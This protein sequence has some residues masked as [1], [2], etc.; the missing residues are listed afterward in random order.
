L[1]YTVNDGVTLGTQIQVGKRR[2]SA[3]N[4]PERRF[5][6]IKWTSTYDHL[7][8][9]SGCKNVSRE[10]KQKKSDAVGGFLVA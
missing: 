4:D 9:G 6:Q 3:V 10:E 8:G 2:G 1:R 7:R 5:D